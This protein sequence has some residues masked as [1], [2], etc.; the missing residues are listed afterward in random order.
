MKK[1]YLTALSFASLSLITPAFSEDIVAVEEVSEALSPAFTP[2]QE[3][4][5]EKLMSRF[6]ETHSREV[7]DAT[8]AGMKEQQ[9]EAIL[10]MEKFVAENKDK[11]FKDS[12]S[13]TAGN[14]EAHQSIM[15]FTDPYCGHCKKFYGDL[16]TF[17]KA[18][19][20]VKVIF[21]D[22]PIMKNSLIAVKAL[23]AAHSQGKYDQLQKVIFESA[24]PL[25]EK[26]ILKAAKTLGFDTKMLKKDMNSSEIQ[27]KI[28]QTL[29]LSKEIGLRGTPAFIIGEKKVV[30]GYK[31]LEELT[32]DLKEA[33][34][35]GSPSEEDKQKNMP[36]S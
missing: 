23:M 22:I 30:P 32:K 19:K 28:D 29:A 15:V 36:A 18:N 31:G 26:D 4:A 10:K 24:A 7:L 1:I 6:L 8:Q 16:S 11:I 25:T 9:K 35:L 33:Y 2:E 20:D 13:P 34:G 21:K 14:P 3:H 17:L 27:E 5:L 12:S